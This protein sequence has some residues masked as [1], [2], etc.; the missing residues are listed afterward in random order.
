MRKRF[1]A[2]F[3]LLALLLPVVASAATYYRVNTSSLRVRLLPEDNAK[4]L[5]SYEKDYALTVTSSKDGWSYVTFTTGREGYVMSQYLAKSSSYKGYITADNTALRTAPKWGASLVGTLAKGTKITVLTH[6]DTYDY[7]NT[8]IGYGY[9]TNYNISKKYVKPSGQKNT[10][11][12]IPDADYVAW[13]SNGSRT[14]NFRTG[15]GMN[16]PVISELP[17]ATMVYVI[18]HGPSWDN[19]Q[20]GGVEGYIMTQFL[21][22]SEPAPDP[23]AP[24]PEP[25]PSGYTA[26]VTSENM[27]Y[28]NV[29][30]GAGM[31]YA[32][33][34]RAEYGSEVTVLNH[35]SAW[36][37]ISQNGKK[38][39]ILNKYLTLVAPAPKPDTDPVPVPDPAPAPVFQPYQ[40]TVTCPAGEKVNVRKGPGKGYTHIARLDPGTVVTVT[41]TTKYPAWVKV[42]CEGGVFGYMMKEFLQ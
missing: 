8:S 22:T 38:G 26:Y 19:V 3:L 28:V 42:E 25:A 6:G 29:H 17:T 15:P 21:T 33:A 34:F 36:D 11:A 14:V 2:I 7:V 12:Y 1:V 35:G 4:V 23:E 41:G 9:V 24:D 18:S 27:G 32:N 16:Y 31:G 10:P 13:V 40:A 20:V 30:N 5:A 39:Y 37:Y